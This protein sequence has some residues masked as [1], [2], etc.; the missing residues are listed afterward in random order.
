MNVWEQEMLCI[1]DM[2]YNFSHIRSQLLGP[3]EELYN[4]FGFLFHDCEMIEIKWNTQQLLSKVEI[5]SCKK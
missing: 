1:P 3:R 2:E 4:I 5:D